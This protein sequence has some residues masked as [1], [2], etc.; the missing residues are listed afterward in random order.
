MAFLF[1]LYNRLN[2]KKAEA[3]KEYYFFYL[4]EVFLFFLP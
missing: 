3:V 1:N 2:Y 4:A